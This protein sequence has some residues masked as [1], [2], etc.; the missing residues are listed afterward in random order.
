MARRIDLQFT[1]TVVDASIADAAARGDGAGLPELRRK[2]QA[3]SG[4]SPP[5][6][7]RRATERARIELERDIW[8]A[9]IG[10]LL[11]PTV[12][13][14]FVAALQGGVDDQRAGNDRDR[15]ARDDHH[16]RGV[17]SD[18]PWVELYPH[19]LQARDRTVEAGLLRAH[20]AAIEACR[21]YGK[22]RKA[23]HLRDA[24]RELESARRFERGQ[25]ASGLVVR[26]CGEEADRLGRALSQV[27]PPSAFRFFAT[28]VRGQIG[29][30]IAEGRARRPR[31]PAPSA[32]QQWLSRDAW[33]ANSDNEEQAEGVWFID[34]LQ[35]RYD[36]EMERDRLAEEAEQLRLRQAAE[37]YRH[38]QVTRDEEARLKRAEEEAR[39]GDAVTE[40]SEPEGSRNKKEE[41][42]LEVPPPPEPK[43]HSDY[44]AWPFH[45]EENARFNEAARQRAIAEHDE[46]MQER[47]LLASKEAERIGAEVA[48]TKRVEAF[49]AMAARKASPAR[50]QSGS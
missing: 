48:E 16:H 46:F 44:V 27:L 22:T 37:K 23:I 14:A 1:I 39:E 45:A 21:R 49:E 34:W 20:K 4:D 11:L 47:Q 35:D 31:S 15:L 17:T 43:M 24:V 33:T 25:L 8:V 40:R 6:S 42:A 32:E 5:P 12:K 7:T 18:D 10:E 9:A 19:A 38:W 29:A 30:E 13:D 50:I 28:E 26:S 36:E 41:H 2:L 3:V